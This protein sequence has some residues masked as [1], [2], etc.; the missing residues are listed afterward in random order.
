[1]KAK[2]THKKL[3]DGKT[4]EPSTGTP[5]QP[6]ACQLDQQRPACGCARGVLLDP[7]KK[8]K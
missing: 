2:T 8:K 5:K 1:M 4:P 7:E 3:P 6:E